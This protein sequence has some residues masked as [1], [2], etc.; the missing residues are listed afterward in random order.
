MPSPGSQ[1]LNRGL[2]LVVSTGIGLSARSLAIGVVA[3]GHG[4]PLQC[5]WRFGG[6]LALWGPRLE[7][8]PQ[9]V[10]SQW[11]T[12]GH[13][14]PLLDDGLSRVSAS[15][16]VELAVRASDH[17]TTSKSIAAS[18]EAPEEP[19]GGMYRNRVLWTRTDWALSAT[20]SIRAGLQGGRP[21]RTQG[22]RQWMV[23]AAG[24]AR[25]AL[26]RYTALDGLC[27]ALGCMRQS[28]RVFISVVGETREREK[29]RDLRYLPCP[30]RVQVVCACHA[31][32][33]KGQ[34][35]QLRCHETEGAINSLQSTVD[36]DHRS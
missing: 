9:D 17:T 10:R 28:Q 26:T 13:G 33:K 7:T 20:D 5:A 36:T 11:A 16:R 23:L 25:P 19:G 21:P 1:G 31:C 30:S 14:S 2:W 8:P 32:T 29:K 35:W 6:G 24:G 22:H 15:C 18:S 12:R 34:L 27:S 4:L 3:S